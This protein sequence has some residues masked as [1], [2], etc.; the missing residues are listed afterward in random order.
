MQKLLLASS[1]CCWK[2]P[3]LF[4]LGLAP[5]R[6]FTAALNIEGRNGVRGRKLPMVGFPHPSQGLYAYTLRGP[7]PCLK[8][9]PK[10][11]PS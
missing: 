4:C 11:E 1:V 5:A 8:Y 6:W 2:K 9:H 7:V 3:E 10:F